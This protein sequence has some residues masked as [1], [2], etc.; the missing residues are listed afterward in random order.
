MAHLGDFR[1]FTGLKSRS[2]EEMA[3]QA[4][5]RLGG[6]QR[7]RQARPGKQAIRWVGRRWDRARGTRVSSLE[8]RRKRRERQE[9]SE[10]VGAV[11]KKV[12]TF[13]SYQLARWNRWNN[14]KS[15]AKFKWNKCLHRTFINS[16]LCILS[17]HRTL[18]PLYL[19]SSSITLLYIFGLFYH[20]IVEV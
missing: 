5:G 20:K 19:S 12:D 10:W 16:I 3:G 2:R 17:D 13:K 1:N 4:E 15:E 7:E 6:Q 9:I 18:P 8:S 14:L 11:G